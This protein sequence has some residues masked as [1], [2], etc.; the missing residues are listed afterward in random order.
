MINFRFHL[1]SLIAVFLALTVGIVVGSTV[2]DQAIVDGL[3]AQVRRVERDSDDTR[4]EN[5][6]LSN[7]NDRLE[8][9][10]DDVAPFSVDARLSGV[11]TVVVAQR[12]VD[13]GAVERLQER[14]R[15]ADA[16]APA[17]VWLETAWT[18][19]DPDDAAR[20]RAIVG[21]A[22]GPNSLRDLGLDALA[23]RLSGPLTGAEGDDVDVLRAL[24][25][26]G[27]VSVD[28]VDGEALGTYPDGPTSALLIGGAAAP[29]G[30]EQLAELARAF[31]TEG[32][33]TIV[34]EL[35]ADAGDGPPVERGEFLATIRDDDSLSEVIGTVDDGELT[36]GTIA[37]VLALEESGRG[38]VGHYGYGAGADS[39]LPEWD[40]Q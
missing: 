2:V 9:F 32:A 24:V 27:F 3:R 7:Q 17:V 13:G 23:S 37:A 15:Q 11:R 25:D 16:I 34:A 19:E 30:P 31:T 39:P 18:L 21:P 4:R 28:G 36:E 35:F 1:V 20:L 12:G 33:P 40:G 14:L 5:E 29:A 8:S 6:R 22:A 10:L 26:A 38:V